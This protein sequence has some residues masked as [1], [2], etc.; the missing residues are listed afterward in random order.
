MTCCVVGAI[1]DMVVA[2][3]VV[4]DDVVKELFIHSR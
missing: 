4:V 2:C 3:V 1:V